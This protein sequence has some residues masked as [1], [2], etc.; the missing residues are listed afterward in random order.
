MS[1]VAAHAQDSSPPATPATKDVQ[2]TT[3]PGNVGPE[4]QASAAPAGGLADIIVT[5]QRRSEN[6]QRVPI[7]VQAVSGTALRSAGVIN[8]SNLAAAVPGVSVQRVYS[9][10]SPYIRGVGTTTSGFVVELPVAV[11]LDGI[12]LPNTASS[13][14]ALSNVARLEVLKG[15]Q[16][17]LFG[18]NA[19][20][21]LVNIVTR[22][23]MTESTVEGHV[24]YGNYNTFDADLY[25]STGKT[26][27]LAIDVSGL[28]HDQRRGWGRNVITGRQVNK[29]R[30]E[31]VTSKLRWDPGDRT[32]VTARVLYA[33]GEGDIGSVI[34]IFPGSIGADGSRATDP[35]DVAN[36][37]TPLNKREQ[38]NAGLRIEQE[39]GFAKLVSLSGYNYANSN[40][41]AVNNGVVGQPRPGQSAINL[42][43]DAH[44]NTFSQELQLQSPTSSS[45]RWIVGAF[46][47][48]DH[49]IVDQSVTPTCIG[50]ACAPVPMPIF[51]HADQQLDRYA[52]FG[53][54]TVPLT[55]RL[56][57]TGGLRYTHDDK[58]LSDSYRIPI[59]GFST[60]V[61]QLPAPNRFG[62]VGATPP[63]SSSS[64]V[65][66]RGVLAYDVTP[67]VMTYASANPSCSMPH[68]SIR[69]A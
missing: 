66:W 53:E 56:R 19:V 31:G 8:I 64:K 6:L 46:Y 40:I 51:I 35:Y 24:G 25:A 59:Q 33:H 10:A 68:R 65:T 37:I 12:Y 62:D 1:P 15:P 32:S 14:F 61:A 42:R 26:G 44:A 16:G 28:Y 47:L 69:R 23:P 30:E 48:N 3:P 63:T 41:F 38:V 67:D 58:D 5:A 17:T 34:N 39:L 29:N 18:R 55:S 9:G 52:A 27:N 22:D 50:N 7:T 57:L 13:V 54:V 20:G 60:S 21:G 45:I 4:S 2:S 43:N 49:F 36:R 11:Y